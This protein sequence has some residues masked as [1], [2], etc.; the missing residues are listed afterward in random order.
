M[1]Q[2]VCTSRM[3]LGQGVTDGESIYAVKIGMGG[4]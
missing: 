4:G 2:K 3:S 1:D